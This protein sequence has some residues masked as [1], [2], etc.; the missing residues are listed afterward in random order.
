MNR[1]IGIQMRLLFLLGI[2]VLL[3]IAVGFGGYR[4]VVR[5]ETD[6]RD[7]TERMTVTSAAARDLARQVDASGRDL[8][9]YA[10]TGKQSY[11]DGIAAAQKAAENDLAILD[12]NIL[13]PEGKAILAQLKQPSAEYWG[14]TANNIQIFAGIVARQGFVPASTAV[15]YAKTGATPRAA[16]AQYI[17]ELTA[18][19]DQDEATA[20]ADALRE[21]EVS[22]MEIAAAGLVAIVLAIVMGGAM[23]RRLARPLMQVTAAA[24]QIAAGDLRT[25]DLRVKT[26]DEL[27]DLA[28]AFNQMAGS[29]RAV[30]AEVTAAAD[31]VASSAEEL[32]TNTGQTA[33]IAQQMAQ[34]INGVAAGATEQSRSAA[35]VAQITEELKTAVGQ[36]A[37]G[38]QEQSRHIQ[39][40]AEAA[41][42]LS[43]DL[44]E[45]TQLMVQLKDLAGHNGRSANTGLETVN[46]T[47]GGMERIQGAVNEASSR[48]QEL[49]Q[50]SLQIGQITQVITDIADQTNLLAL[51]AAIEA[52]RAGEHGKGFAVVAEEVRK[53]AERS[54]NSTREITS[55]ISSIQSGTDSLA[56]AMD[57]STSEVENGTKL[58]SQ[59]GR[60]LEDVVAVAERTVAMLDEATRITDQNERQAQNS[61]Q[62]VAAVAAIIEENT[63]ATEEMTASSEQVGSIVNGVARVAQD[64]AASAEEVAASVEEMSASAEE[65]AASADHLRSVA[66]R[67]RESVGRFRVQ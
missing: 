64:N 42:R 19:V 6:Y 36:V 33:A 12:A 47:V 63:A 39:N 45:L 59:S 16:L 62:S 52:A 1:R 37:A 18:L 5:V 66:A 32:S 11:Y 24:Q 26:G 4:A 23:A 40:T 51:N 15:E 58:A 10:L 29:I 57:R 55:L 60:V 13:T 38:A 49:Y 25:Q 48:L 54:A 61:A 3:L 30:I 8:G 44:H 53:L 7:I 9:W 43:R 28:A 31:A 46:Q 34:A 41:D 67:L 27:E 65:V 50:A 20:R 17:A 21:K 35:Q 22:L 2:Q 14:N 56:K